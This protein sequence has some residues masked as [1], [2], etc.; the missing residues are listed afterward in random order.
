M[1][2][3]LSAQTISRTSSQRIGRDGVRTWD[4][5]KRRKK[6]RLAQSKLSNLIIESHSSW[7]MKM[8]MKKQRK[9]MLWHPSEKH[10]PNNYLERRIKTSTHHL[11]LVKAVKHLA[12]EPSSHLLCNS[13]ASKTLT[14]TLTNHELQKASMRSSWEDQ[15][16]PIRPQLEIKNIKMISSINFNT[17]KSSSKTKTTTRITIREST[18]N[19][20]NSTYLDVSIFIL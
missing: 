14:A 11:W 13:R 12:L 15:S 6:K 7:T 18:A 8:G 16:R 2:K 10:Q 9:I 19:G 3:R 1:L 17:M 5:L 4:L 20:T